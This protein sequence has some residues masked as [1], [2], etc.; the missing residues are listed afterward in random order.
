MRLSREGDYG[1]RAILYLSMQP[2]EKITPLKEISKAQEVPEVFLAK[3]LQKLK[4]HGLVR[5]HR[6]IKG[7][8]TLAKDPEKI[9]LKDVVELIDGP[10]ALNKCLIRPGECNRYLSC[11]VHP[12]W[13]KAQEKMLEVLEG[14]SMADLV[15]SLPP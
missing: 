11:P 5:S 3:I 8:F 10:I 12:I 7:G 14:V 1:V 15:A 13:K 6:G 4:R 9:T 2:Q